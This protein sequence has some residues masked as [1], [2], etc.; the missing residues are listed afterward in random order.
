MSSKAEERASELHILM[1]DTDFYNGF[2]KGYE[3]AE[4]DLELTWEDI[5]EIYLLVIEIDNAYMEA[6][7]QNDYQYDVKEMYQE[8]L[9]RFKERKETKD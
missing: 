6:N 8:V 7:A 5:E 3:Q 2:V 4:K 1:W 9:K